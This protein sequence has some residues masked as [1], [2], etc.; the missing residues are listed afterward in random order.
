VGLACF[1]VV[2]LQKFGRSQ[3]THNLY[4]EVATNIGV[5]GLVVFLFFIG[6]MMAGFFAAH[7]AFDRQMGALRSWRR[8]GPH[9]ALQRSLDR[10]LADLRFLRAVADAAA[11]FIFIRLILGAFGMDLYEIYWWFGA[12]V[13]IVLLELIDVTARRTEALRG[14]A[15]AEARP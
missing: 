14:L 8:G 1:P 12:G 2:R 4:L 10:H 7:G 13:A 15:E 5:Q 3:D 9:T 11:G 6:A